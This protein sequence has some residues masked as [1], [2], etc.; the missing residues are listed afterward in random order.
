MQYYIWDK[1]IDYLH[2][3]KYTFLQTI[4]LIP[5]QNFLILSK[6]T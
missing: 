6:K 2:A 3:S 4:I 1:C 5:S